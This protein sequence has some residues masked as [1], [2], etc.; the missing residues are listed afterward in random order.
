LIKVESKVKAYEIGDTDQYHDEAIT[1]MSHW[2]YRDRVWIR[3]LDG[4]K[5]AVAGG[6]L[7]AAIQNAMNT[8]R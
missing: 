1:V 6:D 4:E 8:K 2:N 7:I 5:V 3:V